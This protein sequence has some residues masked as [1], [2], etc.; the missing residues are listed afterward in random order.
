MTP[1]MFDPSQT[2][3]LASGITPRD[4]TALIPAAGRGT[5]LAFDKPKILFPVAGKPILEHLI[6]LLAPFCGQFVLV[7]SP[8]G[9][10]H[11]EP[12]LA[13]LAPRRYTIA[14]QSE[15]RGMADAVSSGLPLIKTPHTL[16][17]W[18]DQVAVR[19]ASIELAIRLH[20]GPRRPLATCPTVLRPRPYI[21]FERDAA[22]A[23]TSVRQAREGD[24]MPDIGESDSGLFLF[25]T[26]VL[27]SYLPRLIGDPAFHGRQTGEANFLPIFP[28]IDSDAGQREPG[29]LSTGGV[30][31][32]R[33]MNE[34]ESI[35]INTEEEA[36]RV[37]GMLPRT[38]GVS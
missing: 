31:T 18:G 23:L 36:A 5:R 21:H 3:A 12:V 13:R 29:D 8:T 11:V 6:S 17:L 1:R 16:I 7:L 38:P 9:R 33:I 37:A 15:P 26:E 30:W 20:T 27:R 22:G 28:L 14:I 25:Q 19:P 10:E 2:A 34:S 32:A 35:G 24:S 4:W